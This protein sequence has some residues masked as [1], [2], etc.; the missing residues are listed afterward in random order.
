M[1]AIPVATPDTWSSAALVA[2]HRHRRT[3]RSVLA[4][5]A[6]AAV[7]L[8]M[9][10]FPIGGGLSPSSKG[11]AFSLLSQASAAEARVFA[12]DDVV[13]LVSEIVVEP[14]ADAALAA[15][16]W[17]PLVSIGADGKVRYHQ[18]KL[19][20]KLEEGYTIRDESWYDPATH[21]FAHVLTLRGRPVFA[22]AYDGRSVH[23]LVDDEQGHARIADESVA[24]GFEPPKDPGQFLGI[25]AVAMK[26]GPKADL[27]RRDLV[28][29][30]G[31]IKLA[32]G[33]A[34]HVLR[35][36]SL[37]S[38]S[39]IGLD[40]YLRIVVRD[41]DHRVDSLEFFASGKKIYTIRRDKSAGRPEPTYGWDLAG[42]RP[43]IDQEKAGPRSPVQ[44][45]ADMFRLNV[46]A[47]AMARRADYPV[48]LFSRDPAWSERRQII[49][50]LDVATPPH[51]M[52]TVVYPAKDKRHVLLVQAHT[53]NANLAPMARASQLQY[54][55][56]AGIKV[57]ISKDARPMAKILL[58]SIGSTRL[59]FSDPPSPDCT[60]YL[61]E[62]PE[63]TFPVIA[64]NGVLTDA[65]LHGLV[66]SLERV[67]PK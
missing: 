3:I 41:D 46:S 34:A 26:A 25:L 22:N 13:D 67:K 64:V 17:L 43:A 35:V 57:W 20:G 40:S 45:L 30:D 50:L 66:D 15:A 16:R 52:F 10:L 33:A 37:E 5:A 58:S 39:G 62:T 11:D 32:D 59:I 1:A 31:T 23:L 28:R 44:A 14:V 8:A 18:L 48:Y 54:T 27:G 2:P 9:I 4:I 6:A 53:F 21:R 7:L 49:D 47:D 12:A 36:T 42:L 61:L 60:S 63:G 29:E 65:E 24:P 55:S 56:P 19:G 51:R 38:A